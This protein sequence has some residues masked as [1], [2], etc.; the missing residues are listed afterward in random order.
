MDF[1]SPGDF[2]NFDSPGWWP[3]HKSLN[4]PSAT[5]L[6][7]RYHAIDWGP[8]P[9]PMNDA[10]SQVAII[11]LK[12]MFFFHTPKSSAFI[13]ETIPKWWFFLWFILGLPTFNQIYWLYI[14][15]HINIHKL[16]SYWEGAKKLLRVSQTHDSTIM[17]IHIWRSKAGLSRVAKL[18]L[19]MVFTH[20]VCF[21]L[22]DWTIK[23]I[24]FHSWMHCIL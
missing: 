19:R 8:H 23:I 4:H 22:R 1:D 6:P 5:C 18:S 15:I 17:Y 21:G 16:S 10:E 7:Q 24:T 11:W 2:G 12:A 14:Y 9:V 3:P 13:W 20:P